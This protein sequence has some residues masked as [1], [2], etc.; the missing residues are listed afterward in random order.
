MQ[1]FAG[2][3]RVHGTYEIPPDAKADERGKVKGRAVTKESPVTRELWER[4]LAGEGR[5]LGIVP[6]MDDGTCWF[7]CIDVDDYNIELD[8][9]VAKIKTLGL[10][11]IL[12]RTKS[13]GAHLFIFF[14]KPV[15][16]GLL[17]SKLRDWVDAFGLDPRTEVFPKQDK[18]E[19]HNEHGSWINMPYFGGN[20]TTRYAMGKRGLS[21]EEFLAYVERETVPDA[22]ALRALEPAARLRRGNQSGSAAVATARGQGEDAPPPPPEA[23]PHELLPEAPP[24]LLTLAEEKFP[25]GSRNNGLF[26]LAVYA[27][28][29]YPEGKWQPLVLRMNQELMAN[30]LPENEALTIIRSVEKKKYGYKCKDQPICSVCDK[31]L[32]ATREHGVGRGAS[33]R[34][35]D[36]E[37]G[38]MVKVM[39][40]PV[41]WLWTIDNEIVEFETADLRNQGRF[42]DRTIEVLNKYPPPIKP[43]AWRNMIQDRIANAKTMEVPDDATAAGQLWD[44]LAKFC[45]ARAAGRNMDELLMGKPYTSTGDGARSY[46]VSSDFVAYLI[47]Q[48]FPNRVSERLV[49]LWLRDRDLKTHHEVIKGKPLNFWSVPAFRTQTK[50]HDV[51]RQEPGDA[52]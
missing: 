41:I 17:A 47:Q 48:R 46:F 18:L 37:F 52:M 25:E 30:P 2:L 14:A 21:P 51:P 28:K 38:D 50:E 22:A 16:A 34:D 12:C 35:V 33:I 3:D 23:P 45:T 43:T 42:Q 39:T 44:F 27:R 29:A 4:H 5:G 19:D 24:C 32:C 15:P 11:L 13:G 1:I 10:P 49:Y 8:A 40:K 6:I 26:N 31:K 7:G 9:W 20:R 36:L